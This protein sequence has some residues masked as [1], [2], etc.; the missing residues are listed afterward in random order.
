MNDYMVCV[1]DL[2]TGQH[3]CEKVDLRFRL[4]EE[5]GRDDEWH[6]EEKQSLGQT[7]L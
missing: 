6:Y 1:S 3:S 5:R 4:P 7:H 2:W